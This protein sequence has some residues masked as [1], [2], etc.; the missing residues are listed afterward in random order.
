MTCLLQSYMLMVLIKKVLTFFYSYLKRRKQNFKINDTESFFQ[1]FLSGVP[2]GSI[3]GPILIN[4]FTNDLFFFIKESELANFAD[5]NTIYMGC[6]DLTELLKILQKEC[7][8][9][10]NWFKTNSM[11]VNPNTFQLMIISSAK[12]LSKSIFHINGIES[13][14][15]FLSIEIDNKLNTFSS[16]KFQNKAENVHER[17][18]RFHAELLEISTSV[19]METKNS[20]DSL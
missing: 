8:T 14:V 11:I 7:E 2:Q 1:I 18:L 15:T 5:D 16:K 19:S 12:D 3:L 10:I 9:A 13:S 6:K 17:S 20:L 4:P